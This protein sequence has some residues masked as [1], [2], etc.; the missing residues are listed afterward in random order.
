[1]IQSP[2]SQ[3]SNLSIFKYCSFLSNWVINEAD[4]LKSS[5]IL[6]NSTSK[7]SIYTQREWREAILIKR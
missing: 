4:T 1:M 7:K 3:S 6:I 2:G 5:S